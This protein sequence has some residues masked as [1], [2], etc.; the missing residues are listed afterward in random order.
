MKRDYQVAGM[1]PAHRERERGE[2]PFDAAQL[3]AVSNKLEEHP[4][5]QQRADAVTD[6]LEYFERIEWGHQDF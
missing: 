5:G 2:Y 6:D 4:E 3:A 1:P